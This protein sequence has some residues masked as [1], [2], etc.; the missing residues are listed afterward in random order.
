M[1]RFPSDVPVYRGSVGAVRVTQASDPDQFK[2]Y[3]YRGTGKDTL[4]PDLG[5][6]P[7]PKP[8]RKKTRRK[9]KKP[10]DFWQTAEG[11]RLSAALEFNKEKE[12]KRRAEMES[13]AR[14]VAE[15]D[16]AFR[17]R[18][19]AEREAEKRDREERR[20]KKTPRRSRAPRPAEGWKPMTGEDLD[21]LLAE[22]EDD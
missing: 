1:R 13:Y 15:E 22:M 18:W 7:K 16:K 11:K 9:P 17:E 10:V 3:V 20:A 2:P 21:N 14:A 12:R 19:Y 8:K 6:K 5:L 4:T